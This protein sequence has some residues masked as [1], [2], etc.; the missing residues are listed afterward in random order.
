VDFGEM[1]EIEITQPVVVFEIEVTT[2]P[3]VSV[4]VYPPP[5]IEVQ[6]VGIQ[7]PPG[8]VGAIGDIDLGTFN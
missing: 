2:G 5:V 8:G 1:T 6:E 7:G 4:E 3:N